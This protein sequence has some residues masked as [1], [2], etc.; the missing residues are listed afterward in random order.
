MNFYSIVIYENKTKD[1]ITYLKNILKKSFG[2]ASKAYSCNHMQF[3]S[4]AKTKT[5]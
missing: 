4:M 2:F 3:S 1:K 5:H